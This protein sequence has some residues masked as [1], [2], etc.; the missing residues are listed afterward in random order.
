MSRVASDGH[1]HRQ[2][3]QSRIADS[4]SIFIFFVPHNR[5]LEPL[6]DWQR[7]SSMP[8]ISEA[9]PKLLE[10]IDILIHRSLEA[11]GDWQV[12]AAVI[13]EE[14]LPEE[15]PA[16]TDAEGDEGDEEGDTPD[17]IGRLFADLRPMLR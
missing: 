12:V 9:T 2:H 8:T 11:L 3:K 16:D 6:G 17:A 15:Q 10:T 13:D 14:L 7:M 5:S 1:G 4:I